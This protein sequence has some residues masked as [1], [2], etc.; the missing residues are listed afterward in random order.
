MMN[1]YFSVFLLFTMLISC[2]VVKTVDA[3][4]IFPKMV[5][6]SYKVLMSHTV[7]G[8]TIPDKVSIKKDYYQIFIELDTQNITPSINVYLEKDSKLRIKISK[9]DNCLKIDFPINYSILDAT[10]GLE[11]FTL[12]HDPS[13]SYGLEY[14]FTIDIM[15]KATNKI[16]SSESIHFDIKRVGNHLIIDGI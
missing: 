4:Y 2:S 16:I 8:T 15:E 1:K 13:C 14:G 7:K 3:Y 10:Y 11:D 12:S 5:D 6:S 9:M